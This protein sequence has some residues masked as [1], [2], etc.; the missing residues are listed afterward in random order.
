MDVGFSAAEPP[1]ENG[2]RGAE[3]E[4]E[5]GKQEQGGTSTPDVPPPPDG[6]VR[7]ARVGRTG[8]CVQEALRHTR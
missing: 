1:H 3:G 5:G 7:R 2:L 6:R 8:A 4:A